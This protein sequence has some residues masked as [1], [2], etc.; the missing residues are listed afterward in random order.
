MAADGGFERDVV[1]RMNE[2]YITLYSAESAEKRA[3]H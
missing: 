3:E 2:G 1:D